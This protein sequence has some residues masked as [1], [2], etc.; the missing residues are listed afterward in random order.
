MTV[1]GHVCLSLWLMRPEQ[2]MG[3]TI[4]VYSQ[5]EGY[6][7]QFWFTLPIQQP[8]RRN[9][10]HLDD[11]LHTGQHMSRVA[12][13]PSSEFILSTK[14][15]E[16]IVLDCHTCVHD[17]R[18]VPDFVRVTARHEMGGEHVLIIEKQSGVLRVLALY[19]SRC[20]CRTWP[21]TPHWHAGGASRS[22]RGQ[23]SERPQPRPLLT[24]SSRQLARNLPATPSSSPT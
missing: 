8:A 2:L 9:P 14:V 3:G 7:T 5:G 23:A 4:G 18:Q 11:A 20:A 12:Y 21:I 15:P 16:V 6:G 13:E 17:L 19:L 1:C 24:D 22:M 10:S